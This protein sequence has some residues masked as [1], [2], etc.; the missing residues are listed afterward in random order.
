MSVKWGRL[1]KTRQAHFNSLVDTLFAINFPTKRRIFALTCV[2]SVLSSAMYLLQDEEENTRSTAAQFVA[3]IC[4][5]ASSVTCSAA[6]QL[7]LHFVVKHFWSI[8]GCWVAMETM[9]RGL[10]STEDVLKEYSRA[11]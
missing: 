9:I 3:L 11:K 8:P 5:P 6:L 2:P 7:A 1:H 4:E 10:K